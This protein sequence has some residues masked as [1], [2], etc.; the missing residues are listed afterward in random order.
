MGLIRDENPPWL[1]FPALKMTTRSLAVTTSSREVT[2]MTESRV[3]KGK[4]AI[5]FSTKK[6]DLAA[7]CEA[8]IRCAR[9]T[10]AASD[11]SSF[12]QE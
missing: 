7:S 1:T 6:S 4:T 3:T 11:F 8:V 5:P 10:S 9:M 2:A 12:C